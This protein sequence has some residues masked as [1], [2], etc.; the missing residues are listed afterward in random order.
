MAAQPNF[1]ARLPRGPEEEMIEGTLE[2]HAANSSAQG[3]IREYRILFAAYGPEFQR[4]AQVF[5]EIVGEQSLAAYLF[6]ILV[7]TISVQRRTERVRE[8]LLQLG[9]SGFLSLDN[10]QL[11]DY[12]FAPFRRAS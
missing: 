12:Q 10:V 9:S 4:G 5:K 11:N 1:T 8:W 6:G 2:I 3:E 7:P